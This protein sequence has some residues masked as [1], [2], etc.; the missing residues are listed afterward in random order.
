VNN[1]KHIRQA[2][3]RGS[4]Q[5]VDVLY[6]AES[7]S[8]AHVEYSVY[9]GRHTEKIARWVDLNE[10]IFEIPE[11]VCLVPN[12]AKSKSIPKNIMIERLQEII[13]ELER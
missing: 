7:K 13:T 12:R 9:T 3:I 1:L 2:R 5:F 11:P 8:R 6:I 4:R 10:L